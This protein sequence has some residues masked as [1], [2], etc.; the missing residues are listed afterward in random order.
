M[1]QPVDAATIIQARDTGAS[2][3]T[4][5]APT[6]ENDTA[7]A[8]I[9]CSAASLAR[10]DGCMVPAA[11]FT[12]DGEGQVSGVSAG[13]KPMGSELAF[14]HE[15]TVAGC[16]GGSLRI[17]VTNLPATGATN[18]RATIALPAIPASTD[19]KGKL[20]SCMIRRSAGTPAGARVWVELKADTY[21]HLASWDLRNN[22]VDAWEHREVCLKKQGEPANAITMLISVTDLE[23]AAPVTVDAGA[24]AD[25][26]P[27]DA[28]PVDARPSDA[29]ATPAVVGW[30]GDIY[31]DNC[32][33]R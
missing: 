21:G 5:D 20:V 32:G 16:G 25:A 9:T 19:L 17:K 28:R 10:G 2:P 8:E 33:W 6:A 29:A 4:P 26:R 7:P 12:F 13:S 3:G 1:N 15:R 30:S 18:N 27:S 11:F 31:L 14:S 22:S 23:A 24:P